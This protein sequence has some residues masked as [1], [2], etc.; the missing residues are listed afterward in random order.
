MRPEHAFLIVC[1]QVFFDGVFSLRDLSDAHLI[2]SAR[3]DFDWEVIAD[4]A[5]IEGW[6]HII[7]LPIA[8]VASA[9]K[10]F[11][12]TSHVPDRVLGLL[13]A[14]PALETKRYAIGEI[15]KQRRWGFPV[16]ISSLPF[17]FPLHRSSHLLNMI[18]PRRRMQDTF[19]NLIRAIGELYLIFAV[20]NR[21]YGSSY[22]LGCLASWVRA[23][24]TSP[25]VARTGD[26][27]ASV[28]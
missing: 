22:G 20:V 13:D 16:W 24:I 8:I 23:Y 17:P 5:D 14:D 27:P 3:G 19:S 15:L 21:D 11:L 1:L 26:E 28:T 25:A 7:H 18:V 4:H 9:E 2:L 12:G 6:R 10:S